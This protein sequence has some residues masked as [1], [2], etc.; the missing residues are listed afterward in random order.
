[1]TRLVT[2]EMVYGKVRNCLRRERKKKFINSLKIFKLIIT[3]YL[4]PQNYLNLIDGLVYIKTNKKNQG[5][6]KGLSV[7]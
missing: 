7:S 5:F 6:Y 3:F 2:P 1:M 4:M